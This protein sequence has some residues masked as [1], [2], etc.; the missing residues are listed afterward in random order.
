MRRRRGWWVYFALLAALVV[1]D[2]GFYWLVL[3]PQEATP[4]DEAALAELGRQVAQAEAEV[5]RLERIAQALPT[6]GRDLSQ[7]VAEHFHAEQT[8]SSALLAGFE[9]VAGDVGVRP[10]RI[11]FRSFELKDRPELVRMEIRTTVEGG[12]R[13][14]VQFLETLERSAHFYLV[15]RLGLAASQERGAGGDLQLDLQLST[16][17]RRGSA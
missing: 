7:F 15:E 3:R 9:R 4:L 12:Y 14:I 17:L 5:T 10:G 16:Y 11:E 8:G 6:A 13:N 2:T 1:A